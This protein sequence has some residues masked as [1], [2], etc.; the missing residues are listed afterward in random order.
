MWYSIILFIIIIYLL[1][2]SK[3]NSF[4]N[5]QENVKA[6]VFKEL[7]Y[8]GPSM[9]LY[10]DNKYLLFD[11]QSSQWLFKSIKIKKNAVVEYIQIFNADGT[12][13]EHKIIMYNKNK[14]KLIKN[15][16]KYLE[17]KININSLVP[18]KIYIK[19]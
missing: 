11:S 5:K 16:K 1:S 8:K 2:K 7:K 6:I 19:L 13:G 3:K 12:R 15:I 14:T 18:Y 10:K 17:R 9:D 4:K